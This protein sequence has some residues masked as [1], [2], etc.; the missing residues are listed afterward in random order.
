MFVK[1]EIRR[2]TGDYFSGSLTEENYPLNTIKGKICTQ[3][4]IDEFDK[5]EDN[6]E[7]YLKPKITLI[8][9]SE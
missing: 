1:T 7:F 6:I 9:M 2:K 4:F 3:T 8:S 5:K